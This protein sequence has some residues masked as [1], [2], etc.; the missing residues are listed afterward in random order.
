MQL[1]FE[2]FG[3]SVT[4]PSAFPEEQLAQLPNNIRYL[5]EYGWKQ[6]LSDAYAGAKNAE[7]FEGK[8]LARFDSIVKGTVKSPGTGAGRGA[9]KTRLEKEI[10]HIA[11]TFIFA[12][13]SE[14]AAKAG[15][16]AVDKKELKSYTELYQAKHLAR[17][18]DEAE[19]NL[20]KNKEQLE[21]SNDVL[22][23]LMDDLSAPSGV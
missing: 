23:D 5:I 8:L 19:Y 22:A 15:K 21:E 10:W 17:L 6:S 4:L 16:S 13:L 18:T 2:R 9:A 11:E 1:T 12:V 20:E 3:R 7:E 14:R